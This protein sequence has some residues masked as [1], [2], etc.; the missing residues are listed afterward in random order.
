M[1]DIPW[2]WYQLNAVFAWEQCPWYKVQ[3][4]EADKRYMIDEIVV[5]LAV[6]A[7]TNISG[8]CQCSLSNLLGWVGVR[9]CKEKREK[10]AKAINHLLRRECDLDS[11]RI[12]DDSLFDPEDYQ[13]THHIMTQRRDFTPKRFVRVSLSE[14]MKVHACAMA[15]QA[16]LERALL[17]Y[18]SLKWHMYLFTVDGRKLSAGCVAYSYLAKQCDLSQNTIASY[19]SILH[20]GGAVGMASGRVKGMYNAYCIAGDEAALSLALR[21]QTLRYVQTHNGVQYTGT[22]RTPGAC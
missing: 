6:T 14:F 17:I 9:N 1:N 22:K 12:R 5:L 18:M 10:Y 2:T 13:R 16:N 20:D 7:H 19:I 4:G 11:L 8:E 21:D 3:P 15:Y